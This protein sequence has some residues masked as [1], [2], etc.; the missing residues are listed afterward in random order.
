MNEL[1]V[2][3]VALVKRK[4]NLDARRAKLRA[5]SAA[6][7]VQIDKTTGDLHK[8]KGSKHLATRLARKHGI[9]IDDEFKEH[10]R[11]WVYPPDEFPSSKDPYPDEHYVYSWFEALEHVIAYAN[12]LTK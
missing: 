9:V 7:Q 2:K 8:E 11:I 4:E 6:L 3:L 12:I 10:A 1:E 5:E